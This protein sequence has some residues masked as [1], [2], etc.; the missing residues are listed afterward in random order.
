MYI[1]IYIYRIY[2]TYMYIY[3]YIY[4]YI[5]HTHTPRTAMLSRACLGAQYCTPEITSEIVVDFQQHFQWT[6]SQ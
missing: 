6:F 4:I 3:I 2:I 1:Y 5:T